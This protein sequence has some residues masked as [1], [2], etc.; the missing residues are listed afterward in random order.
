MPTILP[1]I[2]TQK[3]FYEERLTALVTDRRVRLEEEDA[4][5]AYLL[6]QLEEASTQLRQKEELLRQSTRDYI[7]E[8]RERQE[9]ERKL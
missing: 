7:I 2:P 3:Q 9:V 4:H 5:R 8:K 1:A 6:A